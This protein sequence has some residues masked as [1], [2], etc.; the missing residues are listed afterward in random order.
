[1]CAKPFQAE[2]PLSSLTAFHPDSALFREAAGDT[3]RHS[4][5]MLVRLW[6]TE[7]APFAFRACPAIYEDVRGWLGSR[8]GVCP[9]EITLLGSAR[10]G[11]SLAPQPRYGRPFGSD[12]DLDLSIVSARL[13]QDVSATFARWE[14]DYRSGGISPLNPTERRYWEANVVFGHNNLPRGFFD[15]NKLPARDRYPL[16]QQVTQAMWVLIEKLKVTPVAPK[17]SKASVRVYESWRA[18]VARV[19]FNLHTALGG[20]AA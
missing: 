20:C 13:F 17:P 6:L 12:S 9:K 11:F 5:E 7:G 3:S 4:R 18:L 14:A 8:L 16:I 10:I 19:S 1:M 15:V 2:G